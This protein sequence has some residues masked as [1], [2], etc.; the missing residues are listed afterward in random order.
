MIPEHREGWARGLNLRV[1]GFQKVI[2]AM[3][4]DRLKE[5][6]A[7]PGLNSEGKTGLAKERPENWRQS[8]S[9]VST[10]PR[11][12]RFKTRVKTVLHIPGNEEN[13]NKVSVR[14]GNTEVTGNLARNSNQVVGREAR[15]A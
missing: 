5:A 8:R 12:E 10:T 3:R 1:A 13:E 9:E 15:L 7:N 6:C 14:P 2:K 4:L 11:E